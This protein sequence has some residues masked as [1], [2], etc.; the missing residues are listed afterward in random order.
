MTTITCGILNIKSKV[1]PLQVFGNLSTNVQEYT[2]S[3]ALPHQGST[4]NLV[5]QA[6]L[7][8][9]LRR[10][11]KK[12]FKLEKASGDDDQSASRPLR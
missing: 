12:M 4:D 6:A 1:L 11:S 8:H 9:T 7:R 10:G 2:R 5:Q 3:S